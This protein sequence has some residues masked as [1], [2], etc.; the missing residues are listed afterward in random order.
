MILFN[1]SPKPFEVWVGDC[2]VQVVYKKIELSDFLEVDELSCA[3]RGDKS[4][5]PT[6]K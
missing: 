1:H 6:G 2:V 3:E 5:G 4:F